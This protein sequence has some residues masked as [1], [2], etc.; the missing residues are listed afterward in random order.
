MSAIADISYSRSRTGEA[1]RQTRLSRS[2]T[3]ADVAWLSGITQAALSNY[4]NGKRDIPV[5]AL[6]A[7]SRVLDVPPWTLVPALGEDGAKARNGS[8]DGNA[9]GHR[10]RSA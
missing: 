10:E 2:M 7:L 4:E 6:I 5:R 9:V 3:Q 1:L 8:A